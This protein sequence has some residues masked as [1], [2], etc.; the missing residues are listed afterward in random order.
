M[1]TLRNCF[2]FFLFAS[3]VT[4]FAEDQALKV[5][6]IKG[7]SGVGLIRLFDKPPEIPAYKVSVDL[8]SQADIMASRI[9]A[10]EVQIGVLPV[11]L[12]AKIASSGK[13][14][15]VAAIIGEGMVSLLTND[16]SI[17]SI[18]D[19]K[20]KEVSCAG[21]GATPEFVFKR[22]LGAKGLNNV[23]LNFSLAYPEIAQS[24]IAGRIHY[25]LL[26]EP[27]ATMALSG[28][29]NIRSIGDIQQEWAGASGNPRITNYPMTALVVNADFAQ[30][31]QSAIKALLKEI[32]ASINWVEHNPHEAALLVEKHNFG[33]KAAIIE[34]AIPRSNYVY[35]PALE[36]RAGIETLLGLFLEDNPASIGNRLPDDN[37]YYH[38]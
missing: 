38:E 2:L 24:L 7:P 29:K 22:I 9:I 14:I 33:L 35:I 15:Q 34:K 11:N 16:E 18:E 27:F 5:Y 12:A 21:Q 10:G 31:N 8:L 3:G 32:E 23:S 19:L 30:K 28:N 20:G 26:P 13:K 37:F 36:A 1:R 4:L 6:V 17:R 25:A